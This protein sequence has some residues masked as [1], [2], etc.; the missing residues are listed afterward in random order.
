MD[1]DEVIK[2]ENRRASLLLEQQ[3][4][5][6][7]V[8]QPQRQSQASLS[9]QTTASTTAVNPF[10]AMVGGGGGGGP[11]VMLD[12]MRIVRAK[13]VSQRLRRKSVNPKLDPPPGLE[14]INEK[15]FVYV[16][17]QLDMDL[18]GIKLHDC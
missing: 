6:A 18:K 4:R 11:D 8:A 15:G 13:K 17:Q 7:I 12:V 3:A 14:G 2:L 5:H 9:S 10:A 1:D 16:R